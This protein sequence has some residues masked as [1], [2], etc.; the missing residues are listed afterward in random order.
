MKART[1]AASKPEA[2]P[3]ERSHNPRQ[4]ELFESGT[5][6]SWANKE[7]LSKSVPERR[8]PRRL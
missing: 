1:R 2:A 7:P 5:L 3:F 8:D 4:L 6:S